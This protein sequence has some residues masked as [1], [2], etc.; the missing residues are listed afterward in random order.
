MLLCFVIGVVLDIVVALPRLGQVAG[1]AL[2]DPDSTMRLVRLDAILAAHAPVHA[3]MR[4]GSGAGTV[5]AWSHLLDSLLLLGA[6][7]LRLAMDQREALHW[8]GVA[9]G[10]LEVGLLCAATA[11]AFAPLTAKAWRWTTALVAAT[12][13]PVA[14]YGMPGVVHHHIL[15]ALACVMTAGWAARGLRDGAQAGWQAGL[16]A[17][18]GLWFSPETMPFTLLAFGAMGLAWLTQ[19][20]GGPAGRALRAGGAALL[21]LVGAIVAVDPPAGGWLAPEIDRVSVVYVGMA[22]ALCGI[23]ATLCVLDRLA[24]TPAARRLLGG[25][26]AM[27]L[28][29]GWIAADPAV[30]LGPAGL[31]DAAQARVMFGVIAEM[32]PV[33]TWVEADTVIATGALGAAVVIGLALRRRSVPWAYAAL[34]ALAVVALGALHQR[35]ATYGAVLGAGM[36]PVAIA[37]SARRF[38]AAPPLPGAL[39][40]MGV[41]ALFLLTPHAASLAGPA[42]AAAAGR[43]GCSVRAAAAL[44]APYAGRVVLAD[45]DDT[46]ELLYRTGVLTVGSL[47]HGNVAAFMR[48]RAAWRSPGDAAAEPDAVRLTGAAAVLACPG[49]RGRS[50]LVADLPADTLLDRLDRDDPPGWLRQVGR[51]ASG[52][53]LYRVAG[54]AAP[55]A[56]RAR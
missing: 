30:A 11:W 48:L 27:L 18:I 45:V 10:P 14:G 33:A 12:A 50:A 54:A 23:G 24:V 49:R 5:L 9:F 29:G 53:V 35:F 31:P 25:G 15:L 1:G 36:L 51:D 2:F 22:L 32:R 17:A 40:R 47:Y 34:C 52:F 6:A 26:A 8:A 13:A 56:G 20:A 41:L 16:W 55:M 19:P 39:D 38:A 46:P 43:P 37:A 4:D 44:L 21:L 42:D 28:L 3:V 7:P